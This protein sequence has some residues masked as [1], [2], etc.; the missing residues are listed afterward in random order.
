[1]AEHKSAQ[2]TR[3]GSSNIFERAAAGRAD[4]AAMSASCDSPGV[5]AA[6]NA[7]VGS[8]AGHAGQGADQDLFAKLIREIRERKQKGSKAAE[9]GA[10]GRKGGGADRRH[11]GLESST[12]PGGAEGP[13]CVGSGGHLEISPSREQPR[14]S[15]E[16]DVADGK[17]IEGAV[18]GLQG[19]D[20]KLAPADRRLVS[21]VPAPWVAVFSGL[22]AHAVRVQ[23]VCVCVFA[24]ASVR[25]SVR[26]ATFSRC[27]R[28]CARCFVL[29]CTCF[30][31][32]QRWRTERSITT[33][34]Q[35][36]ARSIRP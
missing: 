17:G 36:L 16:E 2:T 14:G 32:Y 34:K 35:T 4:K 19:A 33:R 29:F 3:P 20:D 26:P 7:A 31:L 12:Y 1:M 18:G 27:L 15:L 10:G 28:V 5:A 21:P 9:P 24:R 13:E 23:A 8:R 25:P 11:G 6:H 30:V 22:L